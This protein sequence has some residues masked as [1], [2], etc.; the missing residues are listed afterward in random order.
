[1]PGG[2]KNI[3]PTDNTNGF[4]KNPQNINR[5]GRPRKL[6]GTVNIELEKKGVKEVSKEEIKSCYLRLINLEI[7]E[8]QEMIENKEQPVLIRV[9]GKNI[10]S[11][12]GFDIIDK[13]L[14]RS[15]GKSEQK[16]D[17]TTKGESVN[18]IEISTDQIDK[19][20]DKL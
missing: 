3:K 4:Q 13:I 2:N 8:L 16:T 7:D 12:K 14:D 10:L 15:I 18:N 1:M 20:I 19:L 11:G 5:K 17:I 6:V 9:V